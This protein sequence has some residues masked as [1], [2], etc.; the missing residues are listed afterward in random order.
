MLE[1]PQLKKRKRDANGTD[2]ATTPPHVMND[3]QFARLPSR[4]LANKHMS[5]VHQTVKSECEKFVTM[6]VRSEGEKQLD[7]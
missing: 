1:E 5:Q 7:S 2:V 4:V 6:V 3:V